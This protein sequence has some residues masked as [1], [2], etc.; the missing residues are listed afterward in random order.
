VDGQF[1]LQI[2]EKEKRKETNREKS[3]GAVSVYRVNVGPGTRKMHFLP[4]KHTF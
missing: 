2:R 3:K 1:S 4:T